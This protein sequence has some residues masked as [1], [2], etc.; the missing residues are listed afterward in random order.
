MPIFAKTVPD[1]PGLIPAP[2]VNLRGQVNPEALSKQKTGGSTEPPAAPGVAGPP[3]PRFMGPAS[4]TAA[5][6]AC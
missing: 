2:F 3:T 1:R 5:P 6:E 4:P